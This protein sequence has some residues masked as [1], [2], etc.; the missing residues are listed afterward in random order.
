MKLPL[1]QA[2]QYPL[3]DVNSKGAYSIEVLV[4]FLGELYIG[5]YDFIEKEW[6]RIDKA[7]NTEI[8]FV[9]DM[10]NELEWTNIPNARF[11]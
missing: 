3:K 6:K 10:E 1:K 8:T 9:F 2:L 7:N 11:F 5:Y 4:L